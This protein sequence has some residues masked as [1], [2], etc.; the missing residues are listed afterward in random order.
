MSMPTTAPPF[1]DL[2]AYLERWA[3][4][5]MSCEPADR[6]AAEEGIRR[7]YAAAGLAPPERIVWCGGPM[8]IAKRL[9]TASPD[10]P[11]GA[12][13]K[14]EVFDRVRG[15]VGMLA[16]IFRKEVVV[17]AVEISQRG[18]V[19]AALS[20][21][22]RS[23]EASKAVNRAVV[24]AVDAY[25]CR[26]SVRARHL[27]LRWRGLPHLLPRSTFE[28]VVIGPEQV[29]SLGVYEYLHDV[30]PSEELTRPMQG[31]WQIAKSAGWMVPHERV[32]WVSER[33]SLLRVD[34]AA[35]LHCADG[36][37][38]QYPD[39]WAYYAWKGVRVPAWMIE[40]PEKITPD[41]VADVIDPV[42]RNSMIEIM[43]P[44]RFVRMGG[45]SRVAQDDTGIL[46]RKFWGY[47]GVTIGSWTGVEVVNG[48]PEADG[49]RRRYVLRVPSRMRT[50][51]EAVA[52]TYGLSS[53]RYAELDMRT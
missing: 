42:L 43:T 30:L 45:A 37:A 53:V 22:N 32:C 15:K 6:P 52:W 13:V 25:L 4:V 39:G 12:N 1:D 11:I 38:L 20:E 24:G 35:R 2:K 51:R 9:A 3:S 48:T 41:T 21:H 44:E 7:M 29:A 47:R 17:A 14:A 46:W 49:S 8:E 5:R 16:E 19:R 50:P 36:P 10:D 18:A 28:D 23:T 27:A 31:I 40:Q 34:A 26:F 33:P